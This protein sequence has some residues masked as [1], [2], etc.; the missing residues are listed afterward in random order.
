MGHA[1]TFVQGDV[2]VSDLGKLVNARALGPAASE[3]A[4]VAAVHAR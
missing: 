4:P 1:N 2:N 3:L